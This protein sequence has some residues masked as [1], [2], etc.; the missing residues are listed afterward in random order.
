M[1]QV[2]HDCTDRLA[3]RT[4]AMLKFSKLSWRLNLQDLVV[5]RPE[6]SLV[7]EEFGLIVG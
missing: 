7:V 6:V 5:G 2:D 3:V 4:L 1:N